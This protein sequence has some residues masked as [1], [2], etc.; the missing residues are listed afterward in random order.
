[1]KV[2]STPELALRVAQELSQP[3][4][5][6]RAVLDRAIEVMKKELQRGNKIE[7][8]KFLSV[9]VRQG[10]SIESKSSA[11]SALHLPP[12]RLVQMDLDDELRRKIEGSGLYQML[13]VVPR[14]NFFTGVMA[15]RLSSARSEV[16]VVEGE[17]E[18]IEYL[19]TH[20]PDLIVLDVGLTNGTKIC[21]H[22]KA[23]KDT[24]LTA[25]I[26]VFA[27]GEDPNKITGLQVLADESIVEPF[28]L[29]DLVK[30]TESELSRFAEERNYFEH[31]LH[32]KLQTTE[33]LVERANELIGRVLSQSGLSEEAAAAMAV[34]FREAVD[35][36][37]RHGNRY[38]D[39]LAVD[40]QYLVDREK[41]TIATSDEGDGF[42]TEVYLSRGVSVNP[43]DAA[44]ER[45]QAGEAGGLGIMLMLKC[46]DKLE[47]NYAGN[48]LTLTK[49]VRSS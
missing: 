23:S 35:N 47:Y 41:V 12:S 16:T 27:E 15:A 29:S 37:A 32:F 31:E 46:V 17:D 20:R 4:Q 10:D 38:N 13:V 11:D 9:F 5:Q 6:T 26:R 25:I 19:K 40:I 43:V 3:E 30:L 49:Y 44:R 33:E 14:K 24:S 39:T 2:V 28:E 7:L 34:A 21:E 48:K 42:D 45:N 36:A 18:A 8:P 1:M 22:V